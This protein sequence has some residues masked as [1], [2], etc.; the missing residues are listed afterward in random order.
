[1]KFPVFIIFLACFPLPFISAAPASTSPTPTHPSKFYI[2]PVETLPASNANYLRFAVSRSIYNFMRI[3]PSLDVPDAGQAPEGDADYVLNIGYSPDKKDPGKT[4][5][6]IL[7][8]SKAGNTN[9]F[10]KTYETSTNAGIS[11]SVNLILHDIIKD[12][13]K[14]DYA[15]AVLDFD[16]ET[17]TDRYNIYIN[18]KFDDAVNK[19]TFRKSISV[20]AGRSY[21]INII[22]VS[23]GMTVYSQTKIPG[24]NEN[25]RVTYIAMGNV[26]IDPVRYGVRGKKYFY[27]VDGMTAYENE[28]FTNMSAAS[29][30]IL[31]V[32]DRASNIVYRG[33]IGINDGLT[34]HVVPEEEWI[35]Q[36][37]YELRLPGLYSG[38]GSLGADYFPSKFFW[39]GAGCGFNMV[40]NQV[41][42]QYVY[43]A[44]PYIDAGY[45][46]LGDIRE[47][48]RIGAGLTAS[49]YRYFPQND[50]SQ[51]NPGYLNQ[52]SPSYPSSGI[53]SSSDY[54]AGVFAEVE[55]R[56]LFLRVGAGYD[57]GPGT[58]FPTAVIGIKL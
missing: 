23:D 10:M 43:E 30:H 8:W 14:T 5:V 21:N 24:T 18:N 16:V 15:L 56:F 45:Y 36:F 39:A 55:W 27:A 19:R 13:L 28:E 47:D 1:M 34:A 58:I 31:T 50:I 17:G 38:L 9:V 6:G 4:G 41:F 44:M 40:Y 3:I 26:I 52:I 49:Y 51:V 22:R 12:V 46:F 42:G 33:F 29:N 57:F 20:L 7:V 2:L 32:K 35:R 53:V 48:F 37:H 11:G 54:S 25:P